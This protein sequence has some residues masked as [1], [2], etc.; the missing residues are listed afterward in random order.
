MMA[1]GAHYIEMN[2][3]EAR[4]YIQRLMSFLGTAGVESQLRGIDDEFQK[5]KPNPHYRRHW[6][7]PRRAWWLRLKEALQLDRDGLSLRHRVSPN[8]E[9]LLHSA[10]KLSMLLPTMPTWK[11]EEYRSRL[12]G[13]P[14]PTPVLFEL[15]VAAHYA[16]EG[17]RIEWVESGEKDGRRTPEFVAV[18][19]SAEIEIEC[20]AKS[21]NAGRKVW[22]EHFYRL[23]DEIDEPLVRADVSGWVDITTPDKMPARLEWR[24]EVLATVLNRGVWAAGSAT[25]ADGTHIGVALRS[26]DP[27][28]LRARDLQAEA[29][30]LLDEVAFAHV[31]VVA[32]SREGEPTN[33]VFIRARSETPDRILRTIFDDLRSKKDQFTGERAAILCC[34]IPEIESFETLTTGTLANMTLDFFQRHAGS[35]IAGV[36]YSSDPQM[37]EERLQGGTARSREAPSLNFA[38]PDYDDARFGRVRLPGSR[39]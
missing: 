30:R 36:V 6:L 11:R 20:R 17:H 22:R 38:N 1:D 19:P 14:D 10:R 4:R 34:Q 9:V 2:T 28:Q 13:D 32:P 16:I 24:T 33:P 12:L 7:E 21:V 18:G 25:L 15:D 3:R 23:F 27:V 35:H 5:E 31:A 39:T 29:Q 26:G 8:I 37:V